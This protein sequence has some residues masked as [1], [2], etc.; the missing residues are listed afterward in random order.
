MQSESKKRIKE[1]K[2]QIRDIED[3]I[4][5]EA[6][7]AMEAEDAK[8]EYYDM[9]ENKKVPGIYDDAQWFN[10]T[11]A[12]ECPESPFGYCMYHKIH[13]P[14]MDSCVFCHQPYERK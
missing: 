8:V 6:N 14:A 5:E 4:I 10:I 13:D 3:K 1:W 11:D 12:W 2:K 7:K 9:I